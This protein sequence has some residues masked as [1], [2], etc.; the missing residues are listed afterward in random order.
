M[1]SHTYPGL[2]HTDQAKGQ[3][4]RSREA[5]DT[6]S[7]KLMK[8]IS[9]N[10]GYR[11]IWFRSAGQLLGS[12]VKVTAGGQHHISHTN[13]V[14]AHGCIISQW[15]WQKHTTDGSLVQFY[16]FTQL[17]RRLCGCLSGFLPCK[18]M[19]AQYKLSSCVCLYVRLSVRSPVT[20]P[21][22]T[23]VAVPRIT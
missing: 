14:C 8:G 12:K 9:P 2:G 13:E 1:K 3:R 5:D 6:I 15:L 21:S 17:P 16:H 10:V 22:S 18:L 19:L 23:K 4:S 7:H 11:C 20:S